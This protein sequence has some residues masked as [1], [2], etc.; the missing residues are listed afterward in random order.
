MLELLCV[1]C[2]A[3]CHRKNPVSPSTPS[4]ADKLLI[5]NPHP[6]SPSLAALVEY[7]VGSDNVPSE[8]VMSL[9]GLHSAHCRVAAFSSLLVGGNVKCINSFTPIRDAAGMK[10]LTPNTTKPQTSPPR[11]CLLPLLRRG[12][13]GY[14]QSDAGDLFRRG[15]PRGYMLGL[16]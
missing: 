8:L 13:F 7:I 3:S 2:C 11:W 10:I 9:T 16:K 6:P 12:I 4:V 1:N 5:Y 14:A 15:W